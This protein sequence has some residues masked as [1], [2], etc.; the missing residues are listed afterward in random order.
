MTTVMSSILYL[1]LG[2]VRF[3]LYPFT[4]TAYAP[5]HKNKYKINFDLGGN[6]KYEISLP[7]KKL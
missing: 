6:L 3:L 1:T 7:N 5:K 2:Q 4:Q